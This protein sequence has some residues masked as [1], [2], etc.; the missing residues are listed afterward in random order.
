VR[1]RVR[2]EAPELCPERGAAEEMGFRIAEMPQQ[3]IALFSSDARE[4]YKV[5]VYRAAALP[6]GYILH[7]RYQRK[8]IQPEL[9][10]RIGSLRGAR[11]IVFFVSGNDLSKPSDEQTL[12]FH[13]LRTVIV[14]DVD[15]DLTI[16]TFHFYLE[17]ADFVD[18]TIHAGTAASL[19]PP[20]AFVSEITVDEGPNKQ[21]LDRVTQLS[22][23]F[24][25]GN[26]ASCITSR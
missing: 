17:L 19:L 22:P 10:S 11:G 16:N 1:H 20:K 4:L 3:I 26:S 25:P 12:A 14:R 9:L 2:S 15:E 21:W 24:V 6:A 23:K 8:Y 18:S 5:D 7:F 13:S